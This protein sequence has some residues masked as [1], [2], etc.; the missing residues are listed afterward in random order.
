M[1]A[2]VRRLSLGERLRH[3]RERKGWTQVYVART[4]GITAQALSNY[5]HDFRDPDT[6]VL[7]R[8]A[9]FYGV[10]TDWLL[11]RINDPQQQPPPTPEED[12]LV[13]PELRVLFR[14][15]KSLDPEDRRLIADIVKRWRER[16]KQT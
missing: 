16:R 7:Q 5:E 2:S 8:L 11:G 12:P 9:E 1:R 15:L 6:G 4:L 3:A 10:S 13:D 14:D